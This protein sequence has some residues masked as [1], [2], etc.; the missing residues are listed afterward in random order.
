M[1]GR[2]LKIARIQLGISQADLARRLNVTVRTISRWE[3]G[4][5]VSELIRLSMM[6]LRGSGKLSAD[7]N[8]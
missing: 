2:D 8:E 4:E 7:A 6:E 3:T 5:R 1:T